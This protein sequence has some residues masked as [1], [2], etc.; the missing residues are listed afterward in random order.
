[1]DPELKAR[2]RAEL[3][4]CAIAGQFLTYTEFFNRINPTATMGAFPYISHF[5]QIAMEE[6]SHGYPDITFIVHKSGPMPQYPGQIDFRPADPPDEKQLKSL[7]SGTDAL[8]ALYCP[9][10]TN[11]YRP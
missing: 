1:M 8:I 10:R 3:F 4:R 2:V 7:R 5:N 6:R 9:G 11:P